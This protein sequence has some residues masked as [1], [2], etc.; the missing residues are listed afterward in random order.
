MHASGWRIIHHPDLYHPYTDEVYTDAIRCI[1][2]SEAPHCESRGSQR[3]WSRVIPARRDDTA[4]RIPCGP[5]RPPL[6]VRH[7]G[8]NADESLTKA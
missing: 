8:D 5:K 2:A 6:D 7:R 3:G 1:D 4:P